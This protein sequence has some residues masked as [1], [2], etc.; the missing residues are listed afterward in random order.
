MCNFICAPLH[1]RL[2]IP[3]IKILAQTGSKTA[4]KGL[5]V[6]TV[7]CLC[8]GDETLEGEVTGQD[9]NAPAQRPA[10]RRFADFAAPARLPGTGGAPRGERQAAALRQAG[11]Q[12]H[13]GVA[14]PSHPQRDAASVP[15]RPRPALPRPG[16]LTGCGSRAGRRCTARKCPSVP[17]EHSRLEE[18]KKRKKKERETEK[19]EK[20]PENN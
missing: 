1:K 13:C 15:A 6:L 10:E 11:R 14:A 2:V 20:T 4:Q 17:F 7:S 18:K 9:S 8:L 5:S 3:P 16:A 12:R 19:K